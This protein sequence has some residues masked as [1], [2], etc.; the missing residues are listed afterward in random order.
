M[1]VVWLPVRR[2]VSA[3]LAYGIFCLVLLKLIVPVP[4]TWGGWQPW[5]SA[6]R[7]VERVSAWVHPGERK[8]PAL[9]LALAPPVLLPLTG[10][11]GTGAFGSAAQQPVGLSASAS[12]SAVSRRGASAMSPLATASRVPASLSVAAWLM[13]GWACCAILL[14]ARFCRAMKMTQKMMREAVPLCPESLC[15]DVDAL[16][17][18]AGLRGPVRWGVN[19][20]LQFA[21]RRRPA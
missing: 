13:I 8:P 19:F 12:A 21:G 9:K 6:Q 3:Q 5:V 11:L 2:R 18:A 10:D 14:L 20:D 7:T 17:H 15:L 16:G 4:I 1:V